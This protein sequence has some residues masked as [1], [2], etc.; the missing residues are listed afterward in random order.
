ML[1]KDGLEISDLSNTVFLF[2]RILE[3][4]I[5]DILDTLRVSD[6]RMAQNQGR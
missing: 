2:G 1:A 6:V 3:E 5:E 4:L